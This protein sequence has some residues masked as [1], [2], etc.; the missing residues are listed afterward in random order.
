M[1]YDRVPFFAFGMRDKHQSSNQTD[2]YNRNSI[3]SRCFISFSRF[4]INYQQ[5]GLHLWHAVGDGFAGIAANSVGDE[6][7]GA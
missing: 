5:G 3:L 1:L 7:P 4:I 6:K 2:C